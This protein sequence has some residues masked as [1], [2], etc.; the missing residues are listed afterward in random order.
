MGGVPQTTSMHIVRFSIFITGNT[1]FAFASSTFFNWS[2]SKSKRHSDNLL[3]MCLLL[4][5]LRKSAG[6]C[7]DLT[8][9]VQRGES[10]RI[11]KI[12]KKLRLSSDRYSEEGLSK[13]RSTET[14]FPLLL[15]FLP[16]MV[17]PTLLLH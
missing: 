5:I 6:S 7:K 14:S 4:Y 2:V 10:S 15:A 1:N 8:E 9:L 3:G 12:Y 17:F 16:N 13:A 11:E